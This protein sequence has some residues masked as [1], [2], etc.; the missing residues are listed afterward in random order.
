MKKTNIRIKAIL[1]RYPEL[2]IRFRKAYNLKYTVDTLDLLMCRLG[3]K[4]EPVFQEISEAMN[5]TWFNNILTKYQVDKD[6]IEDTLQLY[7]RDFSIGK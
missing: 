6:S 3:D 4:M 2:T 7:D 1:N 5:D